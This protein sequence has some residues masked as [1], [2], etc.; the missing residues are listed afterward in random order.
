MNLIKALIKLRNW[1]TIHGIHS[2]LSQKLKK[3]YDWIK[4]AVEEARG[5]LENASRDYK[6]LLSLSNETTQ[7]QTQ[8]TTISNQLSG[9][10]NERI[11]DCFFQLHDWKEFLAW[12]EEYKKLQTES[13]LDSENKIDFN[14]IRSMSSF[15][16]HD[17]EAC[18]SYTRK[19]SCSN[20][21]SLDELMSSIKCK[22]DVEELEMATIKEIFK[23]VLS[24]KYSFPF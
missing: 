2:F 1:Q 23:T 6:R 5:H 12:N 15:D 14:F 16:S 11:Y 8:A 10:L 22:F 13:M 24:K 3:S 20:T 19:M 17:Y 18:K 7:D 21:Q 4:A 9:Y